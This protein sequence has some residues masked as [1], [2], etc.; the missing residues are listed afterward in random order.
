MRQN[1]DDYPA[2]YLLYVFLMFAALAGGAAI[3]ALFLMK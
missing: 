2:I 1:T 3:A